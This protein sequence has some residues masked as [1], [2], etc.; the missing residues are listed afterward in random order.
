MAVWVSVVCVCV[1]GIITIVLR[2]LSHVAGR[3][4]RK[5]NVGFRCLCYL[6]GS[7]VFPSCATVRCQSSAHSCRGHIA[8]IAPARDSLII[9]RMLS[10]FSVLAQNVHTLHA[11]TS[12]LAAQCLR[13]GF[14]RTEYL[15]NLDEFRLYARAHTQRNVSPG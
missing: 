13:S 8:E 11:A 1:C 15:A 12:P 6:R 14:L 7:T 5:S 3:H 2:I 4:V 10:I 9:I